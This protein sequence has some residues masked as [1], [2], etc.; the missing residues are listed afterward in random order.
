MK[1]RGLLSFC[2]LLL[3]SPAL[4]AQTAAAPAE[5]I[6]RVNAGV[7]ALQSWYVPQTGLYAGTGW[8]NSANAITVLV[9]AS[10]QT[11]SQQWAPV[12]ANTFA[13]AQVVVPKAEQVGRLKKMTGAPGFLN[14]YYD[15]EGWW[16]LAWIDAYDLTGEAR[17]LQMS[18]SI[19]TDMTGGWDKTCGG[20]VWW[21]KNRKHKNAIENELFLSVAAHLATRVHKN[22]E[23]KQWA[24]REWTWFR[25]SGMINAQGL[26]NDGV[27]QD[28]ETGACH[29]NGKQTWTYNQ[30]VILG[31]LAEWSKTKHDA[32]LLPEA[33]RIAA[34]ALDHLTDADGVLHEPCEARHCGGDGIQFKGIFVRNLAELNRTA[35]DPRYGQF[36]RTNAASVW[37]R[38]RADPDRFGVNWSGPVTETGA[39]TEASA[40][41][42]LVAAAK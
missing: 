22:K 29:N 35:P 7:A 9:D 12:L 3:V 28:P 32:K 6:A 42:V 41:D 34:A 33:H 23:Y 18:Q 16:A 38:D 26:V 11:G 24:G 25:K 37:S 1:V 10:R 5:P 39:G 4:F 15:D 21:S 27:E 36:F 13:H 14:K 17:Y 19:F 20:G 31:G 30:G 8:W 40:L 2:L